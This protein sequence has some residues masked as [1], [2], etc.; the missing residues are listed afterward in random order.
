MPWVVLSLPYN[1]LAFL[2][3]HTLHI[4]ISKSYLQ[5]IMWLTLYEYHHILLA[6]VDI[7]R[8]IF[9]FSG[10]G[11]AQGGKVLFQRMEQPRRRWAWSPNCQSKNNPWSNL[12]GIVFKNVPTSSLKPL[13]AFPNHRLKR[14]AAG[15]CLFSG[16]TSNWM[17]SIL[18]YRRRGKSVDA[19]TSS[20]GICQVEQNHR[21]L[22]G[23]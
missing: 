15:M 7:V 11:L 9:K 16:F 23:F 21:L 3:Y 10:R 22:S 14:T 20:L 12:H 17:Q 2:R 1:F 6:V 19:K 13:L 18:W 8:K 5:F 4:N